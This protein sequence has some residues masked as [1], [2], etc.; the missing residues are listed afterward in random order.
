MALQ[1][2]VAFAALDVEGPFRG[3][4]WA[5]TDGGSIDLVLEL[6]VGE[7]RRLLAPVPT[8]PGRW[9]VDGAGFVRPSRAAPDDLSLIHI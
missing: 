9:E 7:S 1:G 2:Q 3:A 8:G 6:G 5:G 4:R